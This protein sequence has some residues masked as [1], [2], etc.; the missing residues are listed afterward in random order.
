[1]KLIVQQRSEIAIYEQLYSQ[2]VNQILNGTLTADECLPSIRVVSRELQ[3][4]VIPVKTAY[5]ML[6]HDGYIYTIQGK[7]CFI[8]YQPCIDDRKLQLV[9]KKIDELV[10]LSKNLGVSCGEIVDLIK[11]RY[12]P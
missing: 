5:E 7:G 2:I 11:K 8:K 3:I 6:E 4:S 12:E 1:M 9:E 10:S